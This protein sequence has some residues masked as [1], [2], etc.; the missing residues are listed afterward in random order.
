MK[1]PILSIDGARDCLDKKRRDVSW[2]A[3]P[4]VKYIGNGEELDQVG[5]SKLL[6]KLKELRSRLPDPLPK[7][8]GK[9]FE[10][11]AC[12][13]VHE[14]LNLNSVAASSREFW[15]W[16]TFG[17]AGGEFA[18]IVDWRFSA[19]SRIDDVNYGITTRAGTWE[20]LFAR[21]WWRGSIGYDPDSENPY[22]IAK[23]GDIDIWRSHIIRQEYGRCANVARALVKYQYPSSDDDTATL[24]IAE[25]RELAKRLRIIDASMSYEMLDESQI[26]AL[27]GE[28]VAAIRA[29]G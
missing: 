16:L 12:A 29:Q 15:L 25:L 8:R 21:L 20:G 19:G 14:N 24:K 28:S 13:L 5:I 7:I 1:F 27:I 2:S 11:P 9:D 26:N 22:E 6:T 23:R 3:T 17:A 18:D 10:A 4:Y